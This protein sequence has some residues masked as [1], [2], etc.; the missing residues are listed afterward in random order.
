LNLYVREFGARKIGGIDRVFLGDWLRTRCTTADCYN[1]HRELLINLWDF[2]ISR[3]L[4]DSNE[5]EKTLR[6]SASRK[7]KTNQKQRKRLT[8]A[9]FWA[10]HAQ[11]ESWLQFAMDYH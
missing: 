8:L 4:L 9:Q 7:I 6:R 5:A 10:I 11:A 1:K 3:K 2:A